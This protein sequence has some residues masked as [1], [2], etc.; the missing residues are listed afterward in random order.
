V[1]TPSQNSGQALCEEIL[2]EARRVGEQMLRS[3]QAEAKALL[4]KAAAEAEASR[5]QRLGLARTEAARR[6]EQLL[7]TVGL[8]RRRLRLARVEALLGSI[9]EESRRRLL[10]RKGFDHREMVIGLVVEAV[11]QMVG[12]SFVVKLPAADGA[13]LGQG[14]VEELVRRAGR[15]SPLSIR[16]SY[17]PA[18]SEGGVIIEDAE[19]RQVWDNR[20]L[21]RL[22]RLW[23]ELRQ[24]LAL[25]ASLVPPESL[26]GGAE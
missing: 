7:A 10:A 15:P 3:A 2:A 1:T 13:T 20:L 23:P 18:M 5:Q 9:H 24:Q 11:T 12:E 4:A 16:L 6:R 19:G 21:A 25:G 17:E 8:E 22:E 14:L 26:T